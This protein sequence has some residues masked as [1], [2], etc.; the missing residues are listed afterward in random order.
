M[1]DTVELAGDATIAKFWG[2][3][4]VTWTLVAFAVPVFLTVTWNCASPLDEMD[5]VKVLLTIC[6]HGALAFI[7]CHL[8]LVLDWMGGEDGVLH[9]CTPNPTPNGPVISKIILLEMLMAQILD[10][11]LKV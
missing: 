5:G 9:C 4:S 11:N 6:R 7:L 3:M 8:S 10:R 1:P 2:M